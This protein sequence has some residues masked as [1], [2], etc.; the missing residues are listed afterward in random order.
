MVIMMIHCDMLNHSTCLP[1][2][3]SHG[4]GRQHP[5]TLA[6]LVS[7]VKLSVLPCLLLALLV[8]SLG[9]AEGHQGQGI[10]LA[11]DPEMPCNPCIASSQHHNQVKCVNR[12]PVIFLDL[13]V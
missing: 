2:I 6:Q 1:C 5:A 12:K 13:A 4:I 7:K 11:Q 10:I 8:H 9:Q 3:W